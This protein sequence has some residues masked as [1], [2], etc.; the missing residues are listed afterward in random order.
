M[1]APRR[2][3]GHR[4]PRPAHDHEAAG[5]GVD[6]DRAV[7]VRELGVVREAQDGL[8]RL[9]LRS[10]FLQQALD[11]QAGIPHVEVLHPRELRHRHP[12][13]TDRVEHD[14]L[15]IF[16]AKAIVTGGDQHAHRQ[17][18]DIPLPGTRKRL[19]EIIY[20]EHKPPLGR[21]E[22]AEV[23]QVRVPTALHR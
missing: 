6:L 20:V 1:G 12:I 15:L 23:R 19:V 5:V 3:R 11:F 10:E 2:H 22:H 9:E 8:L 4:G 7:V 14:P 16:N 21:R 13:A 18:L 17:T